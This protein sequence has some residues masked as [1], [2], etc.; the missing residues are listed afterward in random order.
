MPKKSNLPIPIPFSTNNNSS[1]IIIPSN[2]S[3]N[4]TNSDSCNNSDSNSNN[5]IISSTAADGNKNESD[6]NV[7]NNNKNIASNSATSSKSNITSNTTNKATNNSNTSSSLPSNDSNPSTIKATSPTSNITTS[8]KTTSP[9]ST[10]TS[11][12]STTTNNSNSSINKMTPPSNNNN[13]S[14]SK[15]TSPT[16]NIV[17]KASNTT[18]NTNTSAS[19]TTSPTNNIGTKTS[20]TTNNN[21]I[22]TVNPPKLHAEDTSCT[23]CNK[24]FKSLTAIFDHM[25]SVHK[26]KIQPANITVGPILLKNIDKIFNCFECNNIFKSIDELKIHLSNA[27][28]NYKHDEYLCHTCNK[29]FGSKV[30]IYDHLNSQ[31]HADSK[32]FNCAECNKYFNSKAVL[33]DH[34]RYL[35]VFEEIIYNCPECDEKFKSELILNKH[36]THI[37]HKYHERKNSHVSLSGDQMFK[38]SNQSSPQPTV[39]NT[40]SPEVQIVRRPFPLRSSPVEIQ[41]VSPSNDTCQNS[42]IVNNSNIEPLSFSSKPNITLNEPIKSNPSLPSTV[43]TPN[44]NELFQRL[45]TSSI[46]PMFHNNIPTPKS[47]SSLNSSFTNT[48]VHSNTVDTAPPKRIPH[49]FKSVDKSEFLN[50]LTDELTPKLEILKDINTR[51]ASPL[52]NNTLSPHIQAFNSTNQSPLSTQYSPKFHSAVMTPQDGSISSSNHSPKLPTMHLTPRSDS[53][54]SFNIPSQNIPMAPLSISAQINLNFEQ[55][56]DSRFHQIS[57]PSFMPNQPTYPQK[58]PLP[59]FKAPQRFQAPSLSSSTFPPPIQ[60]TF[61]PPI[62]NKTNS[63]FSQGI[64]SNMAKTCGPPS[65]YKNSLFTSSAPPALTNPYKPTYYETSYFE[66]RGSYVAPPPQPLLSPYARYSLSYTPAI[67][68]ILLNN[69]KNHASNEIITKSN[70]GNNCTNNDITNS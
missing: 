19:K 54:P 48:S 56:S 28:K 22:N 4:N 51:V 41:T 57:F 18:N 55:Q 33:N 39:S 8:T 23:I 37:H 43:S 58:P 64:S 1:E 40:K 59:I 27:H 60:S 53:I 3:I 69:K 5:N 35:H 11:K 49:S 26:D 36:L 20:N 21:N 7:S 29:Y 63:H 46:E 25:N 42:I 44:I 31:I 10:I 52:I 12:T 34:I 65:I 62:F 30:A 67:E 50:L 66:N 9:T 32:A 14:L 17:T 6:K 45:S 47:Q 61:P 68:P 16:N 15:T 13:T 24:K 38:T 2:N 70:F